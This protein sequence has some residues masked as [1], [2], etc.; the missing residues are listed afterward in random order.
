LH[1]HFFALV[2]AAVGEAHAFAHFVAVTDPN[3][4]LDGQAKAKGFRWVFHGDPQI[5]GRYSVLSNFGMVPAALIGLDVGAFSRASQA[6]VRSCGP[7]V[8][9][10]ANPAAVLG[11]TLAEAAKSGRTRCASW[12]PPGSRTW[13][14][15]W[16]SCSPNP[17]G[18]AARA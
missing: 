4:D 13:A 10:A 11:L 6:M 17:P 14:L 1:R 15:G 8:P 12:R 9:P 7:S 18:R 2:A 16:N 5:G 3:S